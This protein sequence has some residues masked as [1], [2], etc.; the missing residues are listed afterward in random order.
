MIIAFF[1]CLGRNSSFL[2]QYQDIEM[3]IHVKNILSVAA[4]S[5]NCSESADRLEELGPG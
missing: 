4:V 3:N 5:I 1:S 2:W